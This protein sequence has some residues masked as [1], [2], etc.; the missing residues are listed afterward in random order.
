MT[1]RMAIDLAEAALGS[2]GKA[3]SYN[4]ETIRYLKV[5]Y[6]RLARDEVKLHELLGA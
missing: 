2:A 5:Q 3:P 4:A 1:L 6:E